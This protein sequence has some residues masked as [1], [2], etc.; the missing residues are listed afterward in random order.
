MMMQMRR[1]LDD[2]EVNIDAILGKMKNEGHE[3]VIPGNDIK[4]PSHSRKRTDIE[5]S[6]SDDIEGTVRTVREAR[7]S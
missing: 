3:V 6:D 2:I 4:R 1:R 7:R 5:T